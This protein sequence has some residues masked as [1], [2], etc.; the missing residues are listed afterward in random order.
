MRRPATWHGGDLPTGEPDA[1]NRPVRFGGRGEVVSLIPTPI[2][3]RPLLHRHSG[4][5]EIV[6]DDGVGRALEGGG[7]HPPGVERNHLRL[8][9][10][11]VGRRAPLRERRGQGQLEAV[12][13]ARGG[14]AALSGRDTGAGLQAL[15]DGGFLA[16]FG[17]PGGLRL[18]RVV[19][20][21]VA[22]AVFRGRSS[23]AVHWAHGRGYAQFSG[24][25][26]APDRTLPAGAADLVKKD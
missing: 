11:A 21:D 2:S 10:L 19:A 18:W 23:G 7:N 24:G 4:R 25:R 20:G 26:L 6:C 3:T 8:R 5:S 1:G 12:L 9:R 17:G 13:P 22:A 14:V 15:A 16:A